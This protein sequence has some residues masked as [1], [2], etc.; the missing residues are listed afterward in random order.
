MQ[1]EQEVLTRVDAVIAAITDV[2]P[3]VWEIMVRQQY[4]YAITISV[5]LVASMIVFVLGFWWAVKEDWDE[6]P[7]IAIVGIFGIV[8]A[9]L[10]LMGILD[11]M[12]RLLNPEYYAIKALIPGG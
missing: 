5:G 3:E 1:I 9:V 2:A 7:W 8:T 12:P 6:G 4:V 11:A 10:I